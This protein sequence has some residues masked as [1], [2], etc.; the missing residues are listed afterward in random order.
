MSKSI[1][2]VVNHATF[3]L[4]HR[5]NLALSAQALG[6]KV[7]LLVGNEVSQSMSR[8]SEKK[9]LQNNID[10]VHLPFSSVSLNIFIDIFFS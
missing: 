4:S 9:L 8:E 6:Y 7:K 1:C 5:L 10:Y 2:Y 3:F